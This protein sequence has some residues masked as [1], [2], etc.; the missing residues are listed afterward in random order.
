MLNIE[1]RR[2]EDG[3]VRTY[4]QDFPWDAGSDYLWGAGNYSCDCNRSL[5]FQYAVGLTAQEADDYECTDGRFA[6]R[7]TEGGRLVYKD[8]E[9]P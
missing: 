9:W 6:V 4:H 2:N 5:F 3:V 1:I 8:G 7:I